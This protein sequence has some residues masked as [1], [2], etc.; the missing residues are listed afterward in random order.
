MR[1]AFRKRLSVGLMLVAL[2]L[3]VRFYFKAAQHFERLER[4]ES[5]ALED[6]RGNLAATSLSAGEVA[7]P[8]REAA[9][10]AAHCR[11]EGSAAGEVQVEVH[12]EGSGRA[13]DVSVL[14]DRVRGT[15]TESC[16]RVAFGRVELPAFSGPELVLRQALWVRD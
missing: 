12:F 6:P 13:R 15:Q 1:N 11:P 9:I 5:P 10:V 7:G 16:I 14:T 4:R 3:S 2:A 8:M